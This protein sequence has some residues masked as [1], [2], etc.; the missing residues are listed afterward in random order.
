M[1]FKQQDEKKA[2]LRAAKQK[3]DAVAQVAPI[4]PQRDPKVNTRAAEA[5][6]AAAYATTKRQM[7]SKEA[8]MTLAQKRGSGGRGK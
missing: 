5:T 4:Q 3:E 1:V 2:A 8:S 6:A 7:F